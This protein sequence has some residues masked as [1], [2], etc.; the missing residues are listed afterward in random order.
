[1]RMRRT[2]VRRS[3]QRDVQRRYPRFLKQLEPEGLAAG[4]RPRRLRVAEVKAL[5]VEAVGEV[6]LRA[7]DVEI[8]L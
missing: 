1:M 3:E 5:A 8:T 6:E 7:F 2:H 4:T